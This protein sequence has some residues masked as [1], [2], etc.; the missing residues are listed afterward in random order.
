ML[1]LAQLLFAAF[2]KEPD[3]VAISDEKGEITWSE[4]YRLASIYKEKLVS[5]GIKRGQYVGIFTDHNIEQVVAIF[6]IAM[7]DGVFTVISPNLKAQ[8]IKH[9]IADADLELIMVAGE[10]L[11]QLREIL[12]GRPTSI[13]EVER[14]TKIKLDAK[15]FPP[16]A[17]NIPAD[18]A[19]LIYTSGSTGNPKGVVVPGKTLLDGARMFQAI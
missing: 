4:L 7:A 17:I 10:R 12:V 15:F 13:I 1:N 14:K 19:C 6:G 11:T 3:K 5:E 16:T 9:Q 2:E 18:V 8:Q